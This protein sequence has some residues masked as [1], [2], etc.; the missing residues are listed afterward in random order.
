MAETNRDQQMQA[1]PAC[2]YD[3][4]PTTDLNLN[5]LCGPNM[6][7]AQRSVIPERGNTVPGVFFE[8]RWRESVFPNV[9]RHL[10]C[11]RSHQVYIYKIIRA[12][13]TFFENLPTF[14]ILMP[15]ADVGS[16]FVG[17]C[18]DKQEAHLQIAIGDLFV[19]ADLEVLGNHIQIVTGSA[20][21]QYWVV[22]YVRSPL[23][24]RTNVFG[25]K[26]GSCVQITAF[27]WRGH[28]GVT[29][30]KQV[31]N[32]G[33][34]RVSRHSWA[35]RAEDVF[36]GIVRHL[37]NLPIY[38]G[39]SFEIWRSHISPVF[40]YEQYQDFLNLPEVPD[41]L[42]ASNFRDLTTISQ[43]LDFVA[44]ICTE[45]PWFP[46]PMYDHGPRQG[47][48]AVYLSTCM[49]A[50]ATLNGAYQLTSS[51][52]WSLANDPSVETVKKLQL[53][54]HYSPSGIYSV[55]PLRL[56]YHNPIISRPIENR[57]KIA[58]RTRRGH[59]PTFMC[60]H[61]RQAPKSQ[62]VFQEPIPELAQK[63]LI[64][65]KQVS[66]TKHRRNTIRQLADDAEATLSDIARQKEGSKK[67]RERE[68]TDDRRPMEDIGRSPR[69]PTHRREMA[70]R[71]HSPPRKRPYR[72]D[73][74][75]LP[76]PDNRGRSI[77][78]L[79]SEHKRRQRYMDDFRRHHRDEMQALAYKEAQKL[80]E[81]M[82]KVIQNTTAQAD[83]M[84][85]MLNIL[86]DKVNNPDVTSLKP[87]GL[88]PKRTCH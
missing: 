66:M 68:M 5:L 60:A 77:Y 13:A 75:Q 85:A 1:S 32:D 56:Y 15:T 79:W 61:L 73:G 19:R 7:V 52:T 29:C 71:W 70:S 41:F 67:R 87:D 31:Y 51:W 74:F 39:G 65:A 9:E 30:P 35:S 8:R 50:N 26:L 81:A 14:S 18:P 40:G 12:E 22:V 88:E 63:N 78:A 20:N 47:A 80:T 25:F 43:K 69:D 44:R 34:V 38:R 45:I 76:M 48:K 28:E 21:E 58:Y 55:N 27:G 53:W 11:I 42:V 59:K 37:A 57:D 72:E 64:G 6:L 33:G 86:V 49:E 84:M 16:I 4:I 54:N 24:C 10:A 62:P 36:Q 17:L 46:P 82:E 2:R 83:A 3:C 23:A